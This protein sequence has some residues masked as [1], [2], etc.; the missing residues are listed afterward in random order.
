MERKEAGVGVSFFW[1]ENGWWFFVYKTDVL[2]FGDT[3]GD[4]VV[5]RKL[6]ESRCKYI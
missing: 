6:R 5:E 1:L 3:D 2:F 4:I